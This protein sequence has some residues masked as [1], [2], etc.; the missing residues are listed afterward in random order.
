MSQLYK[1]QLKMMVCYR[2]EIVLF[3]L[4]PMGSLSSGHQATV[5]SGM[6]VTRR[7]ENM[8]TYYHLTCL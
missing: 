2:M 1:C 6:F 7:D 4:Q 8:C 5:R 3:H